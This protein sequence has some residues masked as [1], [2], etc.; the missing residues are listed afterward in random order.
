MNNFSNTRVI[1]DLVELGLSHHEAAIYLSV[2]KNGE[3]SAGVILDDVKLHREQMYRA[4]KRLV[5]QGYLTQFEKRKRSY[6][7]A[8][9]PSI[10]VNRTKAKVETAQSLQPHLKELY[11]KKPQTIKV[12]KGE[13][14]IKIHLEDILDTIKDNGEYL[15]MGGIGAQFYKFVEKYLESFQRKFK[16]KNLRARILVYQG[17]EH[18]EKGILGETFSVKN[19]N[20]P[21]DVPVSTVIYGDKVAI[22][23]LDP[24]NVAVITIENE[25]IAESYRQNF[26]DLWK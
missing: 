18:P 25:K 9:D 11:Q 19:L 4:L 7:S 16:R 23:V 2:L 10:L 12:V 21:T 6:Y 20:R 22:I 13:D 8:I 3:A 15:V 24:N 14:A 1:D 5:D 26:E 17:S